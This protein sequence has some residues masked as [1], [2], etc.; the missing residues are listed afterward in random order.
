[1]GH[2]ITGG[3]VY[4]GTSDGLHGHYF[5]A[6]FVNGKIFTL[7]FNGTSWVA[8]ERTSQ[9]TNDFGTINNPASFGQDGLGNLYLVD[10]DG[11]VFRLTP[12]VTS[13]DLGDTIN[14]MGG[15]DLI[16]GGA[17][18]D[19]LIGGDGND[20]LQGGNGDDTLS[21]GRIE[22]CCLAA[23]ATTRSTAAPVPT[24]WRAGPAT[25]STSSTARATPWRRTSN[26]GNDIINASINYSLPDN[27]EVARA[28]RG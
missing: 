7:R 16:F 6:D 14:G 26:Q 10:F 5:F 4:R 25:T 15:D 28:G 12:N 9:I 1:M 18:N 21:G 3:Y 27:F 20:E 8:T 13:A 19:T 11:D 23:P 24:R 17:G 2:S 22:I